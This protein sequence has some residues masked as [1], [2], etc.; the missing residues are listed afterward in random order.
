MA[1]RI[2]SKLS[3]SQQGQP[4]GRVPPFLC[5]GAREEE[6]VPV[7]V[8]TGNPG[9][10]GTGTS[11]T[12][13][14]ELGF[15]GAVETIVTFSI[16]LA[17]VPVLGVCAGSAEKEVE[18]WAGERTGGGIG[19]GKFDSCTFSAAVITGFPFCD[20]TGWL[21]CI[22]TRVTSGNAAGCRTFKLSSAFTDSVFT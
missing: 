22:L 19:T 12:T 17:L 14:T 6:L 15:A 8:T 21:G 5:L 9:A 4:L 18:D 16:V 10:A 11:A 1:S 3:G 13:A 20:N 7:T 2:L